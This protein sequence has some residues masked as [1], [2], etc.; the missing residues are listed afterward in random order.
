MDK[1]TIVFEKLASIDTNYID[2]STVTQNQATMQGFEY[3]MQ[4]NASSWKVK[5]LRSLLKPR[6]AVSA[7]GKAAVSGARDATKRLSVTPSGL[8]IRPRKNTVWD[9][10]RSV[11]SDEYAKKYK[12]LDY[13]ARGLAGSETK[14]A[15][16]AIRLAEEKALKAKQVERVTKVLNK[17]VRVIPKKI[18]SVPYN[19]VPIKVDEASHVLPNIGNST[20]SRAGIG[21][22]SAVNPKV[23]PKTYAP[24]SDDKGLAESL[25]IDKNPLPWLAGTGA[26]GALLGSAL[27]SDGKDTYRN[28]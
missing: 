26:L 18:R 19:T 10:V 23:S 11:F 1:S 2:I 8:V 6:A 20:R 12:Q 4:K 9:K 21:N 13:K 16:K 7:S 25:G 14:A 3:E 27:S 15:N 28:Y 17:K 24:D 22:K 5:A